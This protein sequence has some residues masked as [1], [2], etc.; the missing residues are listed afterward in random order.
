MCMRVRQVN[1]S[2]Q[3]IIVREKGDATK[4]AYTNTAIANLEPLSSNFKITTD[5]TAFDAFSSR[6]NYKWRRL[7]VCERHWCNL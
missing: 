7:N 2:S 4:H 6:Q 3:K 5:P 1:F